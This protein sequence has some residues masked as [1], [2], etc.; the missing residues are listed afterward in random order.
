MIAV[1]T[2]EY[3][4]L[5]SNPQIPNSWGDLEFLYGFP[6]IMHECSSTFLQKLSQPADYPA[7]TLGTN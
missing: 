6:V 2:T 4:I 3:G 7:T 1:D 5:N